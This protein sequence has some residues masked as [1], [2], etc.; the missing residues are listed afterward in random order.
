MIEALVT[1][2]HWK[3]LWLSLGTQRPLLRVGKQCFISVLMLLE[4]TLSC[5]QEKAWCAQLQQEGLRALPAVLLVLLRGYC[6]LLLMRKVRLTHKS[7]KPC[8]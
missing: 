1:S 8:V 7:E 4:S 6:F 3:A 2:G 5:G